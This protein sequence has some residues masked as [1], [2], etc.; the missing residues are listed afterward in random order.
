VCG[1]SKVKIS[2]TAC[3]RPMRRKKY[4]RQAA[5]LFR[6]RA[7]VLIDCA[8]RPVECFRL[9]WVHVRYGNLEIPW[10]KTEN[11][12]RK[13]PMAP[14]VDAIA[15]AGQRN[16]DG[17]TWLFP[18]PTASG[19]IE[20]SSIKKQHAKRANW[21]MSNP[22]TFTHFPHLSHALGS[23]HGCLHAPVF[24][25]APRYQD[26]PP[27]IFTPDK[28]TLS[29]PWQGL[30]RL[31]VGIVSGIPPKTRRAIRMAESP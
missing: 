18:A 14:R 27:A 29:K 31:R 30:A 28:R 25:W 23:A 6:D 11:A 17:S 4:L 22:S 15:G 12:I 16:S 21:R 24:G 9:K 13:L 5:P 1:C 19:Y 2:E 8:L 26:H 10:G 3:S 20:P 7:T